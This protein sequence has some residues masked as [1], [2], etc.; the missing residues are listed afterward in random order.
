M[1]HFGPGARHG[2]GWLEER[3]IENE[4]V[5]ARARL[6]AH[7]RHEAARSRKQGDSARC[8]TRLFEIRPERV[9]PVQVRPAKVRPGQ[10]RPG[11]PSQWDWIV[12]TG[13]LDV[14]GGT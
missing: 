5:C 4:S 8:H 3:E 10:V 6:C 13:W 9:R 2:H 7:L 12:G 1:A 11:I 14:D